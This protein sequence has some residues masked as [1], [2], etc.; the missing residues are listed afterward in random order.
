MDLCL[1][2]K[3]TGVFRKLCSR[4]ILNMIHKIAP[5]NFILTNSLNYSIPSIYILV[6]KQFLY[7]SLHLIFLNKLPTLTDQTSA[8]NSLKLLR[9]L[10]LKY[11]IFKNFPQCHLLTTQIQSLNLPVDSFF[12]YSPFFLSL[13]FLSLFLFLS[14]NRSITINTKKLAI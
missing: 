9:F 14:T 8:L 10:L 12:V 5:N 1:F 2:L 11:N 7:V 13:F 4:I 6:S 3:I